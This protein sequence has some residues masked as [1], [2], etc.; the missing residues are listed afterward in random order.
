MLSDAEK[1]ELLKIARETVRQHTTRGNSP[2]FRVESSALLE[3]CGAFVSLHSHGELRGC[4]GYIE[5][6]LPLWET[7][8][9]MAVSA[10]SE[11]SRFEPLSADELKDIEIEISVLS[12]LKLVKDVS[13]IEVGRH[14]LYIK[15]GFRSGL[16]L[17]QV[18]A[19]YGWDRTEFLEET[20]QKAGLPSDAWKHNAEVYL[21]EAQV[22]S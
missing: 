4:V 1:K 3:K 12:P 2:E 22:F 10:S 20:C 19:E 5:G 21:F 18:A 14:G 6:V 13:E 9:E 7:V 16:L 15:K 11:D 8:R 17:P